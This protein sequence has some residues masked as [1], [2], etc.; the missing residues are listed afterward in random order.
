EASLAEL[1]EAPVPEESARNESSLQS[2]P[3]ESARNERA[4]RRAAATSA[5]VTI[6]VAGLDRADG[7]SGLGD[8][9]R[10]L[11]LACGVSDS[12]AEKE[13]L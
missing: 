13:V 11:A 1:D 2:V 5:V 12:E 6:S 3:E 10:A 7:R 8:E 4:S 9:V